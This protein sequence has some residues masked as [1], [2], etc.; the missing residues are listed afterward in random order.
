MELLRCAPSESA[1]SQVYDKKHRVL[2]VDDDPAVLF[3]YCRLLEREGITVDACECLNDALRNIKST[4]YLAVVTDLRLAGTQNTD[5]LDVIRALRQDA[6]NTAFILATGHGSHEIEHE[7]RGLGAAHYF[8][9]PV[10]PSVILEILKQIA[11]S[12][13]STTTVQPA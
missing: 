6:P 13:I 3:A 5:G 2:V 10:N 8:E 7:A 4:S 12:C 11:T 9:K 1:D